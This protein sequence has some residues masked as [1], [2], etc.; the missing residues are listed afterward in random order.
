[1][2]G[3]GELPSGTFVG[4]SGSV[5]GTLVASGSVEGALVASGSVEEASVASG[6][7]QEDEHAGHREGGEHDAQSELVPV[8]CLHM[9]PDGHE[10]GELELRTL[11]LAQHPC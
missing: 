1:M 5:E 10:D 3:L 11:R 6:S 7:R 9:L 4:A 8:E 2:L